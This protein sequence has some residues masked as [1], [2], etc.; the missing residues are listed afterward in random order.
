MMFAAYPKYVSIHPMALLAF[1]FG[2]QN[3]IKLPVQI[4]FLSIDRSTDFAGA[5]V[6][7]LTMIQSNCYFIFRRSAPY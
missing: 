2:L 4:D 7:N 1:V 3:V 5:T 6:E